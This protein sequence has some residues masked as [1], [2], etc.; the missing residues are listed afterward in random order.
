MHSAEMTI[1]SIRSIERVCR[2]LSSRRGEL[3]H[4]V[5]ALERR[6]GQRK[7][8]MLGLRLGVCL[9]GK[10]V[11]LRSESKRRV[12]GEERGLE[13]TSVNIRKW[14]IIPL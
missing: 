10:G 7:I 11:L 12:G 2:L 13:E 8:R 9:N 4:R 6:D 1:L 5:H 14:L 3:I